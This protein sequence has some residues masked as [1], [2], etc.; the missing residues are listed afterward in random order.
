[1]EKIKR[2][3]SL[4]TGMFVVGVMLIFM[5]VY[6]QEY[7]PIFKPLTPEEKILH[8]MPPL[9]TSGTPEPPS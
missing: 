1:M 4:I 8:T 7:E 5:G 6:E 3:Q 2:S 9:D